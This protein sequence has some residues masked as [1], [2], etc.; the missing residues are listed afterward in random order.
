[1]F[2]DP[3]ILI[4]ILLISSIL[5]IG[6][7]FLFPG[8]FYREYRKMMKVIGLDARP[9]DMVLINTLFLASVITAF[10]A[11]PASY[12]WP[13]SVIT[14][15]TV[16]GVL[17]IG[18]GI[19]QRKYFPGLA[20]ALLLYLPLG[21]ISFFVFPLPVTAKLLA[22]LTGIGLHTVPFLILLLRRLRKKR[23]SRKDQKPGIKA[24]KGG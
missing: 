5:H 7:E 23:G 24:M 13:L 12:F 8:G 15:T 22:A 17:H 16:N 3:V 2:I 10:I 6:E 19:Q 9:L 4:W 14:L 21:I 20:T 11:V 18:K 1:M